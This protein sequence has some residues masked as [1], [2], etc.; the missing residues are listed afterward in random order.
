M[1]TIYDSQ[2][3]PY[4][5]TITL[6]GVKRVR[7]QLNIDLLNVYDGNPLVGQKDRPLDIVQTI[8]CIYVLIE[9]DAVKHG[10][11]DESWAELMGPDCMQKAVEAFYAEWF[12][13]FRQLNRPDSAKVIQKTREL[14][15]AAVKEAENR[16]D[17]LDI[18]AIV[19][20]GFG[21][22]SKESPGLSDLTPTD[23]LSVS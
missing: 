17:N 19:R 8:D 22:G 14:M 18:S 4:S 21:S 11:N 6:G 15:G 23:L 5:L 2:Q 7:K 3:R 12:D 16:I 9:P 13:F 10:L 1:P 20:T